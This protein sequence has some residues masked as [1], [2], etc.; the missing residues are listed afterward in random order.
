MMKKSCLDGWDVNTVLT[1][2]DTS[3]VVGATA[4]LYAPVGEEK[5]CCQVVRKVT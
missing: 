4:A 1:M 5:L 3:P 2:S